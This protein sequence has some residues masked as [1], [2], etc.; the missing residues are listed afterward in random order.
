[1]VSSLWGKLTKKKIIVKIIGILA[2]VDMCPLPQIIFIFPTLDEANRAPKK[3]VIHTISK[4][5]S[6]YGFDFV[7]IKG[8]I[9]NTP[10]FI[11]LL[12]L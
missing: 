4:F 2:H 1:V 7:I 6:I 9:S 12:I 10:N 11:L 3:K 8:K 5:K